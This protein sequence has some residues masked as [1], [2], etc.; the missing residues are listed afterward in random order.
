MVTRFFRLMTGDVVQVIKKLYDSPKKLGRILS[1]EIGSRLLGL[2]LVLGMFESLVD[3]SSMT[4][5]PTDRNNP[6]MA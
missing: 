1:T 5:N 6:T 4:S 2:P 3:Y